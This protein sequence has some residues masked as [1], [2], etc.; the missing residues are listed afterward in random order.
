MS[1]NP[2]HDSRGLPQDSHGLLREKQA[3]EYTQALARG[4]WETVGRVL[5]QAQ[6]DPLL[7]G[8]LAEIDAVLEAE[9][10][11]LNP[12]ARLS[13]HLNG[14]L[15][16]TRRSEV[17]S[18]A[19]VKGQRPMTVMQ[20]VN[21][22]Q[23]LTLPY[24]LVAVA[25]AVT[26]LIGVLA[27]TLRGGDQWLAPGGDS[28]S[29][30]PAAV[31]PANPDAQAGDDPRGRCVIALTED[32]VIPLATAPGG[33]FETQLDL[34]A[35]SILT[36]GSRQVTV[37]G[38]PWILLTQETPV[39]SVMGWTPADALPACTE[40]SGVMQPTAVPPLATATP[41]DPDNKPDASEIVIPEVP[42]SVASP[43]QCVQTLPAGTRFKL[44]TGPGYGLTQTFTLA[45]E[46][47]V[48]FSFD[49]GDSA[50]ADWRFVSI[51]T[52]TVT[53]RGWVNARTLPVD[54]SDADACEGVSIPPYSVEGIPTP[55]ITIVPTVPPPVITATPLAT[56]TPTA[57]P[58][59]PA[60]VTPQP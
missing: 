8:M 28:S 1:A 23:S 6:A 60:T 3:F 9:S 15:S 41:I 17:N 12:P 48:E 55:L 57:A 14:H 54:L 5:Q 25:A 19:D 30:P 4:D 38:V 43:A 29:Q 10:E 44:A 37:D 16:L 13:A 34:P 49:A 20:R 56:M 27:L 58:T 21:T 22:R 39:G 40:F 45:G 18:H 7:A 33:A 35:N 2:P 24:T 53:A 42:P 59:L 51:R 31:L 11:A 50:D 46:A 32:T 26:L 47:P 36:A 52:R